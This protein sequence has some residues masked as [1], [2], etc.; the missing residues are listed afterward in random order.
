MK[1]RLDS[2]G[3]RSRIV[4]PPAVISNTPSVRASEDLR[5]IS[6]KSLNLQPA[7]PQ[8]AISATISPPLSSSRLPVASTATVPSRG[9]NKRRT[10]QVPLSKPQRYQSTDAFVITTPDV[11]APPDVITS[12]SASSILTSSRRADEKCIDEDWQRMVAAASSDRLNLVS[13]HNN[14]DTSSSS[15]SSQ[16]SS[17]MPRHLTATRRAN[18]SGTLIFT[19][20]ASPPVKG[21]SSGVT[22]RSI[23]DAACITS[24]PD[25]SPKPLSFAN[26]LYSH[27]TNANGSQRSRMAASGVKSSVPSHAWS[28]NYAKSASYPQHAIRDG[29]SKRP[30]ALPLTPAVSVGVGRTRK[31]RDRDLA[32]STESLDSVLMSR[33][34]SR[35]H[36]PVLEPS[37]K[38]SSRFSQSATHIAHHPPPPV[39][40]RR[41]P[42]GNLETSSSVTSA[43]KTTEGRESDFGAL[44][45]LWQ[46][47]ELPTSPSTST[48]SAKSYQSPA[49]LPRSQ[50]QRQQ[51]GKHLH[52]ASFDAGYLNFDSGQSARRGHSCDSLLT[53]DSSS[54]V[55]QPKDSRNQLGLSVDVEDQSEV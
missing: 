36:N 30:Q 53:G 1:F 35:H 9:S 55:Y 22:L 46:S 51:S 5:F 8:S 31:Y 49:R 45:R 29:A 38:A 15:N 28:N 47:I 33:S 27:G 13:F 39:R 23:Q 16:T 25:L 54:K 52:S 24:S 12:M 41:P 4:S 42:Q 32:G 40:P 19:L 26:P 44:K 17:T 43:S 37:L 3:S 14:N 20:E 34:A 2:S 6:T 10:A 18:N 48:G 21:R 50:I 7:T 11:N